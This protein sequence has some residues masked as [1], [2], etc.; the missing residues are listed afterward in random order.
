VDHPLRVFIVPGSPAG[1]PL[2]QGTSR[3]IS[4]P[5][6]DAAR[7]AARDLL[8]ADGYRVRAVSF[9]PDGLVAYVEERSP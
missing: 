6:A 7:A 8:E 3:S 5:T 1:A 9:T 4:A 2:R